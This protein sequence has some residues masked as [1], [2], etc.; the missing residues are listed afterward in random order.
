MIIVANILRLE[1]K[2]YFLI[3]IKYKKK[4]VKKLRFQFFY[5]VIKSLFV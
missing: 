2:N 3:L 1:S 4:L 5:L